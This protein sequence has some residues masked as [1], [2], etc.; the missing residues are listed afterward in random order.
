MFGVLNRRRFSTSRSSVAKKLSAI[1]LSY[2]SPTDPNDGMTPISWQRLPNAMREPLSKMYYNHGQS[3]RR[4]G[5]LDLAAEAALAR[6]EV[7]QDNGQRLFGV[8]VELAE[9]A[10]L[11]TADA[12]GRVNDK[13][14]EL[15][16]EIITTLRAAGDNGWHDQAT[17]VVDER[18]AFLREDQEFERLVADVDGSSSKNGLSEKQKASNE[19][20]TKN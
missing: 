10:R 13:T 12:A 15:N 8:A 16:D 5:R 9:I 11:R 4:T 17:L 20:R 19:P 1:A 6:R 7:W 3:L 14:E 18:F 2:A